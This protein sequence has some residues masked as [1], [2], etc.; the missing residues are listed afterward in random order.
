MSSDLVTFLN[1]ATKTN[2]IVILTIWQTNWERERQWRGEAH[3]NTRLLISYNSQVYCL[4]HTHSCDF[5][6][7]ESLNGLVTRVDLW[8]AILWHLIPPLHCTALLNPEL[9]SD[10]RFCVTLR[11]AEK[12]KVNFVDLIMKWWDGWTPWLWRKQNWAAISPESLGFMKWRF[13]WINNVLL[14]QCLLS[15]ADSSMG[16]HS[17]HPYQ[18]DESCPVISRREPDV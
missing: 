17:Y 8:E 15:H 3:L 2:K 14:T 10:S 11:M 18:G 6:K 12:V 9:C 1:C 16:P 13:E 5:D 4:P 7:P